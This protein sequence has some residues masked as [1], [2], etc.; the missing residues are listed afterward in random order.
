MSRGLG[1]VYKRQ[2]RDLSPDLDIIIEL[3]SFTDTSTAIQLAN[4]IDDLNIM[5]YEEP[6][7]SLRP[8][9]FT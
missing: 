6:V 2:I 9:P 4:Y 3:H 5:Y 1:D 8:N 7:I